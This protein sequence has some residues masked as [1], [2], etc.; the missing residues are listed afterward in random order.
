MQDE[1]QTGL[2]A[3]I[4][5]FDIAMFPQGAEGVVPMFRDAKPGRNA[6]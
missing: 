5:G 2:D 4:D 6:R 1:H 3:F